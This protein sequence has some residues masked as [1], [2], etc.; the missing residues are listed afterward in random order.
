[1]FEEESGGAESRR[2]GD[3]TRRGGRFEKA[4]VYTA[5]LVLSVAGDEL[6][7][8]RSEA[9]LGPRWV[10]GI[11]NTRGLVESAAWRMRQGLTKTGEVEPMPG[12]Q[13]LVSFF[14]GSRLLREISETVG[15]EDL[16]L[17]AA[18]A[19]SAAA[20]RLA[21]DSNLQNYLR[22]KRDEP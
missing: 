13:L 16:H 4:R 20:D 12:A 9:S 14:E 8:A 6:A 19:G 11:Y 7:R 22:G 5:E 21:W 1:M 15:P 10:L 3:L 2:A 18:L 17:A